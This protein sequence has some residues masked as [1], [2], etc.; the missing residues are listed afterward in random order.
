MRDPK[1]DPETG[2]ALYSE[3]G[4]AMVLV[5]RRDGDHVE[6]TARGTGLPAASY[7]DTIGDWRRMAQRTATVDP[8]A[9]IAA[10]QKRREKLV[11]DHALQL[12]DID[13]SLSFLRGAQ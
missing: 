1:I 12:A 4:R 10:L 13:A 8:A 9:K 5:T 11:A 7:R 6:Y 3:S 2:D